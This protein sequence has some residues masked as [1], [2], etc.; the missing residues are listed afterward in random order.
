[1]KML[2][3]TITYYKHNMT[4]WFWASTS[5]VSMCIL[6]CHIYEWFW[7][8]NVRKCCTR[9]WTANVPH[10]CWSPR[11]H[12][13][14]KLPFIDTQYWNAKHE[15]VSV[16]RWLF[17]T[18]QQFSETTKPSFKCLF[19]WSKQLNLTLPDGAGGGDPGAVPSLAD[20]G[21]KQLQIMNK[22]TNSSNCLLST[23]C[24]AVCILRR[25]L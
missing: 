13:W 9:T 3:W 2:L 6:V 22:Q 17:C 25:L 10:T 7:L 1:M 21:Y 8:N 16:D 24:G 18:K 19:N 5:W 14:V 4:A 12:K 15:Q 11:M 23:G 20:S